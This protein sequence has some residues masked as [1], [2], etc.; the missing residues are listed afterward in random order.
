MIQTF[1]KSLWC[2]HSLAEQG[3][4]LGAE[5][6][7]TQTCYRGY[8]GLIAF[9]CLIQLFVWMRMSG[10]CIFIYIFLYFSGIYSTLD[11]LDVTVG[12]I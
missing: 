10:L 9:S 7:I 1:N 8:H 2:T 4:E 6:L 3:L 11:V 12:I 5:Q